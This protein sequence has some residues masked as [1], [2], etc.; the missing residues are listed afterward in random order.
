MGPV[1]LEQAILDLEEVRIV[2][3]APLNTQFGFYAYARKAAGTTS[4]AE[5]L[6]QRVLP[7]TGGHPVAVV[8]GQGV[9]PNRRTRMSTIRASYVSND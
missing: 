1:D 5:W 6:E 4:I 2:I 8:D 3:R 9:S 7:I